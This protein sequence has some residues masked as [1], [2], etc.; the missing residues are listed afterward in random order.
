MGQVGTLVLLGPQPPREFPEARPATVAAALVVGDHVPDRRV[1]F[2]QRRRER[3]RHHV[4]RTMMGRDGGKQR[5]RQHD[6][7]QEC[8]LNDE[9]GRAQGSSATAQTRV[10]DRLLSAWYSTTAGAGA[11][12]TPLPLCRPPECSHTA[13]NDAYRPESPKSRTRSEERRVGKECRS[14]WGR[15][16]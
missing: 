8:G 13:G 3:R 10:T 16:K 7:A 6:V 5:R 15:D 12:G 2:E 11:P 4:D 1:R 9:G 14:R